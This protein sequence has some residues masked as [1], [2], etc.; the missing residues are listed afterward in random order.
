MLLILKYEI[1]DLNII[2][3]FFLNNSLASLRFL[4]N[5]IFLVKFIG[6]IG[7]DLGNIIIGITS[8][9]FVPLKFSVF[10]RKPDKAC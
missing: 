6:F 7:V 9:E 10:E 3:R 2:S 4:R 8:Y 5:K 1:F